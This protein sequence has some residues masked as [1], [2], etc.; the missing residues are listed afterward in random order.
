MSKWQESLV[1]DNVLVRYKAGQFIGIL[2]EVGVIERFDVDVYFSM[3]EKMTVV[4]GG[5]IVVSLLD[6]TDVECEIEIE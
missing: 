3:V 6:G 4:D 1:S 2:T 5:K